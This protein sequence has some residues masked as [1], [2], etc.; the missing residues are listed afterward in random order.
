MPDTDAPPATPT[1]VGPNHGSS[2]YNSEPGNETGETVARTPSADK[3]AIGNASSLAVQANRNHD[4]QLRPRELFLPKVQSR[5]GA[6]NSAPGRFFIP[7]PPPGYLPSSLI[8]PPPPYQSSICTPDSV[9]CPPSRRHP[10][11]TEPAPWPRQSGPLP[12]RRSQLNHRA[13]FVNTRVGARRRFEGEGEY[14]DCAGAGRR[15]LHASDPPYRGSS[16][17]A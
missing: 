10:L 11:T 6:F 1:N 17:C 3:S 8:R 4:L 12:S 16:D 2:R 7:P 5:R 13:R 15:E 14:L 9:T